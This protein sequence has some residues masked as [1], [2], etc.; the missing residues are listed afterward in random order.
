MALNIT[1]S[2]MAKKE[3]SSGGLFSKVMPGMSVDDWDASTLH[4]ALRE[5]ERQ[6][7]LLARSFEAQ[8]AAKQVISRVGCILLCRCVQK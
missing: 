8:K 5:A 7:R 4:S 6:R 1:L 3:R 2:M